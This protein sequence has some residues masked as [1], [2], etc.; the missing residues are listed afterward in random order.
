MVL[1]RVV[2]VID[3]MIFILLLL[4]HHSA[5]LPAGHTT[6]LRCNAVAVFGNMCGGR[7]KVA[8]TVAAPAGTMPTLQSIQQIE[9]IKIYKPFAYNLVDCDPVVFIIRVLNIVEAGD[10]PWLRKEFFYLA[11]GHLLQEN[12]KTIILIKAFVCR[13]CESA[14]CSFV[15][16]RRYLLS[17]SRTSRQK[18]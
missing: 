9:H 12:Q 3:G 16:L 6:V 7:Q 2:N 18:L 11:K 15:S 8:V 13:F 1:V 14:L 17:N 10:Q 5:V 4:P